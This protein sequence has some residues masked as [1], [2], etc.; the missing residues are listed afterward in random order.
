MNLKQRYF[1]TS[2]LIVFTLLNKTLYYDQA[3][4]IVGNNTS[5]QPINSC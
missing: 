4:Q 2:H 1:V 3:K 5:M